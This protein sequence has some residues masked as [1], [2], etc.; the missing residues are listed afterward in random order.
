MSYTI[1]PLARSYAYNNLINGSSS[2]NKISNNNIRK[3]NNKTNNYNNAFT[4][5]N[6]TSRF[7]DTFTKK[8]NELQT[9]TNDSKKFYSE[10]VNDFSELKKSSNALKAYSSTSAFKADSYGSSN[11]NVVTATKTSGYDK[12][13]YSVEVSQLAAGKSISY[14][15]LASTGKDLVAT[16]SISIDNGK[17]SYNFD[18]GT[19]NALNNK[20]AMNKIADKVNKAAI[21]VKATVE[22]VNGK[23]SLE[24]QSNTTGENSKL[25]VTLGNNLN[26]EMTVKATQEGVNAKY[27]VNNVDYTSESNNVNLGSTVKAT[28][29]G[30]G[31]AAISSDNID[32]NRIVNSV[33]DFANDYNK[34]VNFL[35]SN[36]DKSSKIESLS[37]SFKGTKNNS[38]SLSSIGITIENDGKL[39]VNEN[40]LKNAISKDFKNVRDIL[41]GASGTAT[42]TYSKVQDAMN[43]S[44][45]LYPSFQFD[46]GEN[47][48][49][50]YKNTNVI[51]SQY[52][53]LYSGGVFLNSLI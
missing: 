33:K 18:V 8:L 41:G 9:Y 30:V 21:G 46:S 14:N 37:N 34:V 25:T 52:S 40:T 35:G 32:S 50:S 10:F 23:S 16:G 28:L 12:K 27:K 44:K 43:K 36:S 15:E 29:N 39:S 47:S 26:Q 13:N 31:K 20:D 22:E 11:T 4:S 48:I 19:E 49:Y 1:S 38:D 24:F 45:N 42:E 51:Y 2:L 5:V 7:N 3:L 6:A 53:S 17:N